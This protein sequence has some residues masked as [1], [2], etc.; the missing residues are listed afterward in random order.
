MLK[1]GADD[2][3]S[4]RASVQL[5]QELVFG[6]SPILSCEHLI[7]RSNVKLYDYSATDCGVRLTRGF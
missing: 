3:L 6:L 1:P 2:Y 5:T 4:A 7:N